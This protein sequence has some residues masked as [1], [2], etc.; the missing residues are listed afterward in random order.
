MLTW[1]LRVRDFDGHFRMWL[2][3]LPEHAAQ[4]IEGA[5]PDVNVVVDQV[6]HQDGHHLAWQGVVVA[7]QQADHGHGQ[8]VV[9]PVEFA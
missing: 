8:V 4:Q 3:L 6:L 5:L 7:R 9:S 2:L 1:F